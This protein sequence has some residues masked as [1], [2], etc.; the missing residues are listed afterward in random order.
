MNR[1]FL[2]RLYCE[3]NEASVSL[4]DLENEVIQDTPEA[5]EQNRVS[6]NYTKHIKRKLSELIELYW[7]CHNEKS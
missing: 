6:V 1:E 2:E 3:F 4:V 7:R 5:I